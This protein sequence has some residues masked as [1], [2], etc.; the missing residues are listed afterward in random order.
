M[1]FY[2]EIHIDWHRVKGF[3]DKENVV[4]I[5]LYYSMRDSCSSCSYYKDSQ[6]LNRGEFLYLPLFLPGFLK[7]I[8]DRWF[9]VTFLFSCDFTS[10][11]Q[12]AS[13]M[14][15]LSLTYM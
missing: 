1:T 8:N 15:L 2:L 7:M 11:L 12:C 10:L 13:Y 9:H 6:E 4:N 3:F 5:K 14:N